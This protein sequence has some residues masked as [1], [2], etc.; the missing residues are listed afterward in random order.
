MTS[1][2]DW[3]EMDS[4]SDSE[5]S[6]LH[7]LCRK[8]PI[9]DPKIDTKS[10]AE[11]GRLLGE[12][13]FLLAPDGSK[14][15]AIGINPI[16]FNEPELQIRHRVLSDYISFSQSELGQFIDCLPQL[17]KSIEEEEDV[18]HEENEE[19]YEI[20]VKLESYDVMLLPH[21]TVKFRPISMPSCSFDNM[22]LAFDA[23]K[24]FTRM[25]DH[26]LSQLHE[27]K[28]RKTLFPSIDYFA[29]ELADRLVRFNSGGWSDSYAYDM[30]QQQYNNNF[31]AYDLYTRYYNHIQKEVSRMVCH[32]QT[33]NDYNF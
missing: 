25:G 32:M 13:T 27:L 29:R 11:V 6:E 21:R 12:R 8:S 9:K 4:I 23:L 3:P 28:R 16:P 1:T 30:I 2:S 33:Y 18:T 24:V 22:C 5:W 15:I 19:Q 7:K 17:L 31:A 26:F 20:I 10:K 14:Y